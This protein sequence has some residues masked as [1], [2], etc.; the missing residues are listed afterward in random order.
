[1]P[2]DHDI[3]WAEVERGERIVSADVLYVWVRAKIDCP[4]FKAGEVG[5]IYGPRQ[6]LWSLLDQGAI[7]KWLPS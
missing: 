4:W 6:T 1:M 2:S 7:E 5:M 3:F